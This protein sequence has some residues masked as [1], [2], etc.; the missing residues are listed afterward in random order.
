[1][2]AFGGQEAFANEQPQIRPPSG[3]L[4]R[5]SVSDVAIPPESQPQEQAETGNAAEGDA[6]AQGGIGAEKEAVPAAVETQ[7]VN[8][9]SFDIRPPARS[10]H[11]PKTRWQ[12]MQGHSLW[13]RAAISALKSH[14]SP[15]VEMVPRDIAN[16]CPAYSDNDDDQRRAFWVGYMSALAKHESTY[17]PWAVG[18]G[19]RWYGLLQILPATARGYK[20]NVGTGEALKNGAAN[21]SCAVRI[22][23][24]TVKR[25]GVIHGRDKKWRGVSADWGPM[26]SSAKRQDMAGWLKRQNY[27]RLRNSTRPKSRP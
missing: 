23:A 26:R 21:L 10:P 22:M 2:L 24:F 8:T 18:G 15:L 17:K 11:I 16:W 3:A 5:S 4:V 25:D 14:G 9:V 27:C 12:H 1:M 13:T 20:C 6:G 7:H 19:G